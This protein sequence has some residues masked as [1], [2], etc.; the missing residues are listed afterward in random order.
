MSQAPSQTCVLHL[1]IEGMHC[2]SC[3]AR[4]EKVV[5]RM[6]GVREVSVNLATREGRIVYDPEAA[7][8]EQIISRIEQIGYGAKAVTPE[9]A[10]ELIAQ[11]R[12][13]WRR[14]I[15]ELS[16]ATLLAVPVAVSAMS[17]WQWAGRA[18]FEMGATAAVIGLVGRTFFVGAWKALLARSPDMNLLVALGVGA[19]FLYSAAVV[20]FP[21]FWEARSIAPHTY[22]EAAAVI[23]VF[24]ALGRMLEERARMHTGDAVRTLLARTPQTVTRITPDGYETVPLAA[25]A[26]G[27]MLLVRPGEMLPVDG[28]VVEGTSWVDESLLTGESVPVEKVAGSRVISG[29]LNTSGALTVRAT[30]VGSGTVLQRIVQLVRDAQTTKPPIARLAD[31]VSAVFVPAV[32]AIALLAAGGWLAFGGW[33][34]VAHAIQAFVS[35][36]VIACPC[37]LGLAT[38]TAIVVAT[39]EAARSGVLI[40]QA[41]ALETASRLDVLL[42]DKTGTITQ[43]RPGVEKV[44][45]ADE[46]RWPTQKVL[47]LAAWAEQFSEHPLARALLAA[48]PEFPSPPP[49]K[50]EAVT[51]KGIVA[52]GNG[53]RVLVGSAALLEQ[54][55]IQAADSGVRL[56]AMAQAGLTPLAVALDNACVG[57]IGLLDAPRPEAPDVV[58]ALQAMGHEVWMVTG[59]RP[60]TA[61]AIAAQVGVTRVVAGIDPFGKASVVRELQAQGR[62]VGFV[63][64]GIND[65]PALAQADVG[66]A[67]GAGADVAV[68]AGDMTLLGRSLWSLAHGIE[69]A[70]ETMATIRQ[71]LFFA[72][73]YNVAC[74]PLAAGALYPV[75]H[76]LLDPM[77]A[78]AA[79]AA[80]SVSVVTNSLWLGHR[81]RH[82]RGG[83]AE[84]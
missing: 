54:Y 34:A 15:A 41:E 47:A 11:Q 67:I 49:E 83:A 13:A 50:F 46:S 59:D 66:F 5:G 52:E 8:P 1:A 16:V 78:S 77:V 63:G 82:R 37:A 64:D 39:G 7:T 48:A 65:A 14:R 18:I 28:V 51:G 2:A 72:F 62:H 74:I 22:F 71:N 58:K 73:V 12:A 79:M 30:Q 23:C 21:S 43:G 69:L 76:V 70:R 42:L 4:I 40:R 29:T 55:G 20:F 80:S 36:L 19:A 75:M 68:E 25:V 35:V 38:H 56:A 57:W 44:E 26:V 24:V 32:L 81:L 31:R 3:V 53:R 6:P 27:D 9:S 33:Q 84:Q 17:G 45:S 61:Q 60:E 10:E